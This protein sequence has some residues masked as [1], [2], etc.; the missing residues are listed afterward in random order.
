M[1][2]MAQR[3]TA[4]VP[5]TFLEEEAIINNIQRMQI[6]S[7]PTVA[8][9]VKNLTADTWITADVR[10]PFPACRNG[11]KDHAM[12]QLWL[13]FSLGP[14]GLPCASGVEKKKKRERE[15]KEHR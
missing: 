2:K 3:L 12:P 11:L 15:K 14:Q 9:W 13:R 4:K 6:T 8:Q 10:V 5:G 1:M 7:I